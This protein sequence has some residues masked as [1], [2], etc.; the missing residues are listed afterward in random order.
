MKYK[1]VIFDMDGVLIDSEP[2]HQKVGYKMMHDLA[3][4]LDEGNFLRFTGTTVIS[5]WKT[6]A[7][8]YELS[9]SPEELTSLYNKQFTD[10]LAGSDEVSLFKGVRDVLENLNRKGVPVA[11]ASSSNREVIESVLNHF[12]IIDH[13]RIIVSGSDIRHSKPDPE[14]FL[15]VAQ[16]LG[17][18]PSECI[19]IEDSS[20]GVMAAKRAGMFCVG[21]KSKGNH[22]DITNASVIVNSFDEVEAIINSQ[23]IVS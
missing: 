22:Q 7:Q 20:N 18:N 13:F 12:G 8:E 10:R 9:Q 15:K 16:V 21:F 4:P 2:L 3:I 19:V 14:I 17:L 1:A 11:V 23:I 6:L 5:M